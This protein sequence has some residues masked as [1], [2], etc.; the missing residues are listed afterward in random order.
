MAN[1][2]VWLGT[3][4]ETIVS[5]KDVEMEVCYQVLLRGR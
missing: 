4:E 2:I 5:L 1:C 3:G